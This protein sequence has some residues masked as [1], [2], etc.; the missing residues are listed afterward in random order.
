ML[1]YPEFFALLAAF[2]DAPGWLELR[3]RQPLR[4][5][6]SWHGRV[7]RL[8]TSP[9]AHDRIGRW[10][11]RRG[12]FLDAFFGLAR[13]DGRGGGKRHLVSLPALW[14][15]IDQA[16]AAVPP[17]VPPPTAVA[18]TGRGFHLYWALQEALAL[19][20]DRI[21]TVDRLLRGLAR[22]VGGDH[23]CAEAAHLLRIPG[24]LNAKYR[25]PVLVT[26]LTLEPDRRY[27]LEA[28]LPFAAPE[29]APEDGHTRAW[30][31][32]PPAPPEG[33]LAR[34]LE[35]CGFLQWARARQAEVSEPL[36]YAAL[37]N[38]AALPDGDAAAW[39]ASHRYPGF[40]EAELARKLRH[41][42]AWGRPTSCARIHALGFEGCPACPWWGRVR[43]PA[44]IAY[45]PP[46]GAERA[47]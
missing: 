24:T 12:P 40:S 19:T 21:G 41:A 8:F 35:A 11:A 3:A 6:G 10:L 9:T 25:P 15:D 45:K 4:G 5:G 32:P 47:R 36:W 22:Q 27:P 1:Q 43:A 31:G 34:V 23:G 20:P 2:P 28:F 26:L 16:T 13:R 30:T 37:T 14:A 38:L 42:R 39:E 7:A 29:P 46:A 33:A 44:G 17:E 18:F